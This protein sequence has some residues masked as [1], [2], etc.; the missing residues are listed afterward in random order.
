MLIISNKL[1]K[2]YKYAKKSNVN[3]ILVSNHLL[4]LENFV[5]FIDIYFNR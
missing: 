2:K 1:H 3:K 5:F 4:Y